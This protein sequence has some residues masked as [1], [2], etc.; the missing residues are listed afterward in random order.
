MKTL[1]KDT[2]IIHIIFL[3]LIIGVFILPN[4]NVIYFLKVVHALTLLTYI[5]VIS[6]V[7][8]NNSFDKVWFTSKKVKLK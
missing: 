1:N 8:G 2:L 4:L 5:I 3:V 6:F 7:Y